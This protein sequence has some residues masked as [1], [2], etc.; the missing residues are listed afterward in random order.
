MIIDRRHFCL[1][2]TATGLTAVASPLAA[3]Q[4]PFFTE[5]PLPDQA[6]PVDKIKDTD[7]QPALE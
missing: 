5:S 1:G 6:P 2:L 4:N 3:Q 7:Y